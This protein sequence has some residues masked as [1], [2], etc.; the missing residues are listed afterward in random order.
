MHEEA[1][2]DRRL[3]G[4]RVPRHGTVR[5]VQLDSWHDASEHAVEALGRDRGPPVAGEQA[6]PLVNDLPGR[7]HGLRDAPATRSIASQ[8]TGS[9][10]LRRLAFPYQRWCCISSTACA[11]RLG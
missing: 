6:A 4:D 11:S 3:P 7:A 8:G 5:D 9:S 1:E 2:V 10:R